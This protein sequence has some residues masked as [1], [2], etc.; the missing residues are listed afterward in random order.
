MS[1][2][3][4]KDMS[5]ETLSIEQIVIANTILETIAD[6]NGYNDKYPIS[7]GGCKAFYTP[8]EWLDRGEDYGTHSKL[9][10]CHDGG[11][12]LPYFSYDGTDYGRNERMVE[13]LEKLGYYAEQ[14]TCWYTAIYPID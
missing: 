8:D 11:D 4:T 1:I 5:V 10:V 7:G 9:I 13:A 2:K 3:T 6:M 14:C 12:L